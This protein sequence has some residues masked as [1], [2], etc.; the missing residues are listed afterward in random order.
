MSIRPVLPSTRSLHHRAS[1]SEPDRQPRTGP[2]APASVVKWNTW[3]PG[4]LSNRSV[5]NVEAILGRRRPSFI[6][7]Q[8]NGRARLRCRPAA[9]DV[10]GHLIAR[11]AGPS[12]ASSSSATACRPRTCFYPIQKDTGSKNSLAVRSAPHAHAQPAQ[13]RRKPRA[14][15]LTKWFA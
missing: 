9:L 11:T 2:V 12:R 7:D 1:L 15:G 6:S 4:K 13:S 3:S 14:T 10:R 5:S 8:V